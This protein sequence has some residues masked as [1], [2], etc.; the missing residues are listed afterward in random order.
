MRGGMEGGT[1][2]GLERPDLGLEEE[3]ERWDETMAGFW[4]WKHQIWG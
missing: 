3:K 4:G 1:D 2:L